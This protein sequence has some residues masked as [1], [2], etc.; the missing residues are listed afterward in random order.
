M[1]VV[2]YKINFKKINIFRVC[3]LSYNLSIYLCS[4]LVAF[5]TDSCYLQWFLPYYQ[6]HS[7]KKRAT[8][9]ASFCL[10][11]IINTNPAS[12]AILFLCFGRHYLG[13]GLNLFFFGLKM[14]VFLSVSTPLLIF[15]WPPFSTN[16]DWKVFCEPS[17]RSTGLHLEKHF[18]GENSCTLQKSEN[19]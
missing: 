7:F 11:F 4:C 15:W 6:P 3:A 18:V 17:Y 2:L 12:Q 14:S 13:L 16:I 19:L 10:F 5:H 8:I 1:L 9:T